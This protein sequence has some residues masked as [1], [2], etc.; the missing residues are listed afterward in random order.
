MFAELNR[1]G[2]SDIMIYN[3]MGE[4]VCLGVLVSYTIL[5]KVAATIWVSG[6]IRKLNCRIPS[7]WNGL[8]YTFTPRFVVFCGYQIRGV[9][10][11][12]LSIASCIISAV[13]LVALIWYAVRLGMSVR[14]TV[15]LVEFTENFYS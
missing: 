9:T 4:I 11:S 1:L 13:I 15:T 2:L 7:M 10:S 14:K 6:A 12:P 5:I 8:I 3:L